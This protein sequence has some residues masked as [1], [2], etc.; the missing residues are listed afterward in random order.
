MVSLDTPNYLRPDQTRQNLVSFRTKG[1]THPDGPWFDL[2]YDGLNRPYFPSVAGSLGLMFTSYTP[3]GLPNATSRGN[4]SLSP[5]DYDPIQRLN[6]L[7]H[8]FPN[9]AGNG[10]WTYARNPAG[11]WQLGGATLYGLFTL[12][13]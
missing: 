12:F 11:R 4:D 10:L 13:R 6:Y 7:G 9:A 3:A 5:Y 2:T 8:W 1:S